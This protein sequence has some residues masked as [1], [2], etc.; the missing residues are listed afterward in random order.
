V[1]A[2]SSSSWAAVRPICCRGCLTDDSGTAA[3][4]KF[5]SSQPTRAMSSGTLIPLCVI[6]CS[7][8]RVT[9]RQA[10]LVV[11]DRGEIWRAATFGHLLLAHWLALF[12]DITS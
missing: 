2:S 5:T 4:A 10:L 8:Q 3:A 6:S 7:S 9:L 1:G 11:A 12:R